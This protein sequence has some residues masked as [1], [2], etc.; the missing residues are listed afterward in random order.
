[1]GC[2]ELQCLQACFALSCSVLKCLLLCVLKCVLHCVY[3]LLQ[4][5]AERCMTCSNFLGVSHCVAV[6]YNVLQYVAVRCRL[7]Q[8]V[9]IFCSIL[10]CVAVWCNALQCDT[11]CVAVC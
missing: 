4:C 2:N 11:P 5:V 1:M 3:S 7:M 6:H 9:A 8:R 10:Q